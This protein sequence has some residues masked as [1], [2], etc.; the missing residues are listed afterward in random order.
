MSNAAEVIGSVSFD[1]KI[2]PTEGFQWLPIFNSTSR[3]QISIMP[4][5]VDK[6]KI[7]ILINPDKKNS[8]HPFPPALK[9]NSSILSQSLHNEKSYQ[10]LEITKSDKQCKG[11]IETLSIEN[12][13]QKQ[14]NN[15]YYLLFEDLT[16][17]LKSTKLLL[18]E[19]NKLR[20]EIQDKI[21]KVT[22]EYEEN[23]KRAKAREDLLL[24]MLGKKDDELNDLTTQIAY[25]KTA[26]RNMNYE[27]QQIVDVADDFK[28]ELEQSNLM[29][30]NKELA[31]IKSLLEESEAQR[32]KLQQYIQEFPETPSK[33]NSLMSTISLGS[34][35]IAECPDDTLESKQMDIMLNEFVKKCDKNNQNIREKVINKVE[36][37]FNISGKIEVSNQ[38]GHNR[39]GSMQEINTREDLA[40]DYYKKGILAK[41]ILSP[42]A[43]AYMV[44]GILNNKND[45][46]K[47]HKRGITVGISLECDENEEIATV[48]GLK[49]PP[50]ANFIKNK[51]PGNKVNLI[52]TSTTP[53]RERISNKKYA[54][55]VPFK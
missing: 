10:K 18:S 17:E 22:E 9:Q 30:L 31:L 3:D 21:N 12:E 25:L 38:N 40:F 26:L 47:T 36:K 1:L 19:E 13:K 32:H 42:S 4:E 52:Q 48:R 33:L 14:I 53:L 20:I 29:R 28:K 46:S 34:T 2:L 8:S 37:D 41:N 45:G 49:S 55:K 5:E 43:S 50:D 7:L 35:I 23:L 24:K 27:K 44:N 16:K 11:K 6:G 15:K 39:V 51:N 54:K